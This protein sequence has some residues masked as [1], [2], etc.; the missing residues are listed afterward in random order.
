MAAAASPRVA[1][2]DHSRLA[3]Q[4][5]DWRTGWAQARFADP[6]AAVGG[7]GTL[8]DFQ[9]GCYKMARLLP[10]AGLPHDHP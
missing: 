2:P 6:I 8:T 3:A 1:V 4:A 7:P 10:Q 9:T 5:V